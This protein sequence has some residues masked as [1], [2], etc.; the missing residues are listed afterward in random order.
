MVNVYK[1]PEL[2]S[3]FYIRSTQS[4]ARGSSLETCQLKRKP[5]ERLRLNMMS[6]PKDV[7]VACSKENKNKQGI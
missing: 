6:K 5:Q 4:R 2:Q 1:Y 7:M 3:L